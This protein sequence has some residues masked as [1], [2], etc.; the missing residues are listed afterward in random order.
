MSKSLFQRLVRDPMFSMTKVKLELVS[1]PDMY[2]FFKKDMRGG[3]S[4]I[5]N[6]YSKTRS[7]YLKSYDPK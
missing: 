1:N 3:L 6:R 4:Y 2:I 7:K 5:S